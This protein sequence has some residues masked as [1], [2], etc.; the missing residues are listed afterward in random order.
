LNPCE[1][2][3]FKAGFC[4]HGEICIKF[5]NIDFVYSTKFLPGFFFPLICV[6]LVICAYKNLEFR[7]PILTLKNIAIWAWKLSRWCTAKKSRN[8]RNGEKW[9]G[10]FQESFRKIRK[11]EMRT[12]QPKIKE[13]PVGK[14]NVRDIKSDF[15]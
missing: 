1:R 14:P 4:D 2:S 6:K 13:I 11:S 8:F 15:L 12:S 7:E 10:N 5:K 3:R 9:Y